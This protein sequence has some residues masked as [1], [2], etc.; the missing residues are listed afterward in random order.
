MRELI[1]IGRRSPD[2]IGLPCRKGCGHMVAVEEIAPKLA[3]GASPLC[4]PCARELY[5][6]HPDT[7]DRVD[8][9]N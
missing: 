5:R 1:V 6:E 4:E 9:P 7:F 2:G 8:G 3:A